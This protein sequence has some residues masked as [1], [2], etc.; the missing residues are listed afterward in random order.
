VISSEPT[1]SAAPRRAANPTGLSRL[2]GYVPLLIWILAFLTFLLIAGKIIGYGFLP[3]DDALRHAAKAVSGK[4]WSQILVM[5]DDFGID[6]HP[7][8][9]FL[10]G[11]V[12]QATGWDAEKLVVL[13]VAGMLL[14]VNFVVLPWLRWPESWLGALLLGSVC[15][16]RIINRMTLGRPYIFTI[17]AFILL[18]FIW[19]RLENR[20]PGLA[21]ILPSII[22]IAL[23]SW[24]HGSWYQLGLPIA[25]L[26]LSNRWRSAFWYGGCW[27]A[28]SFLGCALTGHPWQF[29][30]QCVHHL[31]EVFGDFHVDRE[32]AGELLPSGGDPNLILAAGVIM[33]WRSRSQDWNARELLNPIFMMAVFGWLLGLK[34]FR[35]WDD[36]GLP[37]LLLWFA[38]QFQK[39]L[40]AHL[41]FNSA[42]R[43]LVAC[44]LALGIFLMATADFSNRYT[45]NLT[46]EYLTQ[47]NPEL[48]GWL[49]ETNGI[50]YSADMRVFNDTFFKN[51]NAPWRYVLG[52]ESGLMRSEDLAVLRKIQWNYGDVRAY[53]PW[54][55]RMKP[56]DRLVLRASWLHS[57]G[58]PNI[59]ELEWKYAVSDLWVGRLPRKNTPGVVP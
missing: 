55:K 58:P 23:A 52:F 32:L 25:G 43:L 20:K 18:I 51:P 45:W 7:G 37:A 41:N 19:T 35:F 15:V 39:E 57:P 5:R 22:L 49:P 28:G 56:E 11:H 34:M 53:E 42:R 24:L 31:L 36:W 33:L 30:Y 10:L 6:P 26:V 3:M 48:A 8:W 40:A 1:T 21:Q 14:L 9:H 59:P 2:E 54:V 27:A 4:P 29:L 47:N 38:L 16:P 12:H 50:L 17:A 44:G 46:N 13:C